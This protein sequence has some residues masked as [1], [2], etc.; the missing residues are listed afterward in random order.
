MVAFVCLVPLKG[1]IDIVAAK[2]TPLERMAVGLEFGDARK[3]VN[4]FLAAGYPPAINSIAKLYQTYLEQTRITNDLSKPQ[5][6]RDAASEKLGRLQ[7]Y[8]RE[9]IEIT[10]TEFLRLKFDSMLRMTIRT[11]PFVGA[12]LFGFLVFSHKDDATEKALTKPQLLQLPWSADIESQL[13]KAGMQASCYL[14]EA[15]HFLQVSEKSGLRAGVLVIP[16][17]LSDQ[18]PA[19]RVIVTNSNG[20]YLSD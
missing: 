19:V 8:L 15:P 5:A 7:P 1:A 11:L 12:A 6:E 17:D 3:V 10:N 18:C 14:K 20:V 9:V 4:E 2:L 13:K 16:H